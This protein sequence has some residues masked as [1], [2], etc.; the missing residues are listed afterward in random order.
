[1][2][3]SH[4]RRSILFKYSPGHASWG[5]GRYNDDLRELMTEEDQKLMLEPPYVA[6]RKTVV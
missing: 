1:M 2:D 4:Q 6:Q 3:A 5:Q